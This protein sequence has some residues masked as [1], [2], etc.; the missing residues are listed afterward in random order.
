MEIDDRAAMAALLA[1]AAE[2][3]ERRVRPALA[4]DAKLDAAMVANAMGLAARALAQPGTAW[5][6]REVASGG[7]AAERARALR[8]HVRARLAVAN[9][10]Y[11]HQIDG[12]PP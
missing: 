2:I 1:T 11:L 7:T 5:S 3:L 12:A 9:P 6:A 10:G 8:P 4:G